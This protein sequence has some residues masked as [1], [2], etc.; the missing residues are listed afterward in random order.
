MKNFINKII[1]TAGLTAMSAGAYAMP[2]S[3][4][5][6]YNLINFSASASQKIEN[7]EIN[8]TMT[9]N[10]QNKSHTELAKRITET[11]NQANL[12]AKKYPTVKVATGNQSTYPQYDKNSKING[13]QGSAS[14]N[15]QSNDTVAMSQLIAELQNFMQ[16]ED[17]GFSVSE[18][19]QKSVKQALML[20]ASK[21]FQQQANALLP[22]WNA[23]GYELVSL[24]FNGGDG[25]SSY[26][27]SSMRLQSFAVAEASSMPS[28]DFQTG[29]TTITVTANGVIQL[30]K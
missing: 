20:E 5:I 14:L 2:K 17:L 18:G 28:Q 19:K 25:Y 21:S 16:L 6:N 27:K 8:A 7:D 26:R 3:G 9:K 30:L 29:D 1:L 13:W 11:L 15:L 23:K 10:L 12:I 24:D 22:A 4:E